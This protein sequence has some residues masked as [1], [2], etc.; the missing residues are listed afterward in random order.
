MSNK[1]IIKFGA[2]FVVLAALLIFLGVNY[3]PRIFASSSP[4]RNTEFI[5][6]QS[7]I[8]H[9]HYHNA[10]YQRANPSQIRPDYLDER[11]PR[12]IV[13]QINFIGSDWIERHPNTYSDWIEHRSSQP[14]Q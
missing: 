1:S 10:H 4:Q 6:N 3:V 11:Y 9:S 8:L 7:Y 5:V 14:S 12:A 13:P 2:A